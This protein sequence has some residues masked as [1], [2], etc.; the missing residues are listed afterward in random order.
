MAVAAPRHQF[1]ERIRIA[2]G[3]VHLGKAG[4]S[5]A[6][7]G[8]LADGEQREVM[9]TGR[10]RRDG[11]A[12]GDE[13]GVQAFGSRQRRMQRADLQQRRGMGR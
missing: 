12:A 11:I 7:G 8:C 5:C 1:S 4:V 3:A 13:D 9:M 6:C 10:Q 2:I